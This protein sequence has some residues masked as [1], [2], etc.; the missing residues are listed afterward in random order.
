MVEVVGDPVVGWTIV[1]VVVDGVS[2]V[3]V[4]A[5]VGD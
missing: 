4:V 1:E 3:V 2:V 5:V